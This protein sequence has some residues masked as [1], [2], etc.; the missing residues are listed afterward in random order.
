MI[1]CRVAIACTTE[2]ALHSPV[3]GH[4]GHCPFFT[5]VDLL[6]GRPIAS[7]VVANPAAVN[8]RPGQV[9]EFVASEGASVILAGGMGRMA[10]TLF[11]RLGIEVVTGATG[12]AGTAL[13]AWLDG[14]LTG[15][16]PCRQSEEHHASG[17]HHHD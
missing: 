1:N 16:V 13:K 11:D 9:P 4:F 8:H 12:A 14:E 15:V 5:F 2:E 3:S 10:I 7:R 6:D 17:H